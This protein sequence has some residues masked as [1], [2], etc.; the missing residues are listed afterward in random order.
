MSGIG[1]TL[2]RVASAV[3][4]AGVQPNFGFAT[5][6][7][8][9]LTNICAILAGG[10]A[11][12]YLFHFL[13]YSTL[14]AVA[15]G[16]SCLGFIS[17]IV[18]NSLQQY[19]L[20]RWLLITNANFYLFTTASALGREAGEQMI[21]FPVMVGSVLVFAF[22]ERPS[23][24]ATVALSLFCLFLLEWTDYQLWSIQPSPDEQ[25][26][27]YQGNLIITSFCTVALA[28]FSFSLYEKQ[29]RQ[30]QR[31][32]QNRRETEAVINYFSTSL[33]GKNTVDEILWDIAKN[34]IARLKLVDCVIYLLD[35]D[36]QM[37][38]QKA[39][40]GSKNPKDFDIYHPIEI[41]VG[42]GIVGSVA[43]TGKAEI[44]SDTSL[45]ARYIAD[46][47]VRLS[48]I[49]VPLVY[50]EKVLG[51]IDAE[52]PDKNFF[53]E[54]H[55]T[56]L[57]II[58]ALCSNKIVKAR[59]EEEHQQAEAV[60]QEAER[61]KALDEAKSQFFANV[62]HEFRTPLTLIIG[63]LEQKLSSVLPDEERQTTERMLRHAQRLL[64]LINQLLD[65][66]KLEQ[67]PLQ[68]SVQPGS[69]THFLQSLFA[70]FEWQAQQQQVDYQIHWP[71]QEITGYFDADKLDKIIY[72]LL[73]NAFKF[74]SRQGK[75]VVIVVERE[76]QL[77]VQVRNSGKGIPPDQLPHIFERFYQ[78]KH[79]ENSSSGGSGIGLALTQ[80]LVTI[81]QGTI[82]VE[83]IP[84]QETVF[85][86]S[87]PID[88]AEYKQAEEALI[89]TSFPGLEPTHPLKPEVSHIELKTDIDL[90]TL[91]LVEDHHDL[92][93]YVREQTASDYQVLEAVDGV[94]GWEAALAHSPDLIICDWMM[95]R[96]DG[97]TLCE[98]LKTDVRTSH[99]PV[100]ML[101]A[102]AD[103]TSRLAGLETGADVYLVKP[104]NPEE[105][106]LRIRKL[107][108]QRIQLRSHFQQELIVSPQE[109]KVNST[110]ERFL[111]Q[112]VAL[113]DSQLANPN[114]TVAEWQQELNLSRMHLHRKLKAL[115][116]QS[117]TEFIR[118]YRL[119]RAAQLLAQRADN[120]SQIAYQVGFSSLAYFTTSFKT[121]FGCNPSE[122]AE[123]AE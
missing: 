87:I 34:C 24:W 16:I 21:Y 44:I 40:Y 31:L 13:S 36:H 117:A 78:A 8:I 122:Y 70:S 82:T 94:E 56:I 27:Y 6:K 60:R 95:P 105:L 109:I 7:K 119:K 91:L 106:R 116:G 68:L 52:H 83:S 49:A 107:V 25:Q 118:T 4:D 69:L 45:D 48:E 18:F 51:V 1:Y 11:F 111:Q 42:Q 17:T 72:N 73:S 104:F 12:P 120:V 50:Q 81:H 63:P 3:I 84:D 14:L 121:Q 32:L 74:T 54:E 37:L 103:Q 77:E 101:T 57:E 15:T 23:W 59:A 39:A 19:S 26:V 112:A 123:K 110:D 65:F 20:A 41:P 79:A 113:I 102:R 2:L 46:D 99:I 100:I 55:L 43:Q 114:F 10:A 76:K 80:E 93:A 29:Y 30:N 90:P 35:D 92:R 47:E 62:T 61:I 86:V 98:R 71:S 9:R 75:V 89:E 88:K 115:T 5:A 38:V 28:L 97:R 67:Q 22:Q 53:T 85:M 64:R 66:A 96:L 33:F 108:E 58:A